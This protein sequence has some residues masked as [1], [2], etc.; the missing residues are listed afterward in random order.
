MKLKSFIVSALTACTFF[1]MNCSNGYAKCTNNPQATSFQTFPS[2]ITGK[3]VYHSYVSYGDGSSQLW[4]YDFNDHTLTQISNAGWGISDPMNAVWSPD[5]NWLLF[6]GI[7]NNAWNIFA[8]P[9]NNSHIPYNLTHSTGATRNEDPKFSADGS[10]IVFKQNLANSYSAPFQVV[11]GVPSIGALTNLTNNT[12]QDSMPFLTPNNTGLLFVEGSG[13][14]LQVYYKNLTSGATQLFA[15][16]G[17]YPIVR[18]DSTIFYADTTTG[19]DQTTY[20]TSPTARP[21]QA[22]FNDC[23]SD[24][25]DAW[26]VN[27]SSL[28]FFSGSQMGYYQIYLGNLTTGQRW[29]LTPL[30]INSDTTRSYLG[31]S[32]L[33]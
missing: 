8:W 1:T 15:G 6:M 25:S 18:S 14:A 12:A 24:N 5:G 32:Y 27:G 4:V 16:S 29:S 19:I 2:S 26:P 20:K 9:T 13:G 22:N 21:V 17:Y 31:A 7:Q 30:G 28:V 23:Q 3:L 10:R 33:P 11:G